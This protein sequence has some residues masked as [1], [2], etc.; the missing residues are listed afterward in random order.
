MCYLPLRTAGKAP[1][2]LILQTLFLLPK[3]ATVLGCEAGAVPITA[4]QAMR[5]GTFS[6]V[7]GTVVAL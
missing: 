3:T 1:V 2:V 7:F 5:K 4:G 6:I